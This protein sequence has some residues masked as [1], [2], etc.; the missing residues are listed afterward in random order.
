M[1]KEECRESRAVPFDPSGIVWAAAANNAI[2]SVEVDEQGRF[3]SP[4]KPTERR[5]LP[6][7]RQ[8]PPFS[9]M[10]APS[11]LSTNSAVWGSVVSV[12][13][14]VNLSSTTSAS[15]PAPARP[16]R[17][18]LAPLNDNDVAIKTLSAELRALER[19]TQQLDKRV[20]A[21]DQLI[22]GFCA[23]ELARAR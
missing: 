3:G 18:P 9:E 21:Q 11:N 5:L 13:S 15:G 19:K 17:T 23:Q 10:G 12:R 7:Q 6:F 20:K 4:L 1:P 16:T 8:N 14:T 2:A 22:R